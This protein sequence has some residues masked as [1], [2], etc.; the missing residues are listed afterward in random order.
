MQY[1]LIENGQQAGPFTLD[2]LN[3]KKI[4]SESLVWA[5]G[6]T[7]WT[8]AWKVEEL[9]PI[10]DGTYQPANATQ[11]FANQQG[12]Q[13]PPIPPTINAQQFGQNPYTQQAMQPQQPLQP[14]KKNKTILY[15][16]GAAVVLLLF[17]FGCSNPDKSDHKKAIKSELNGAIDELTNGGESNDIF[18]MG[19][20]MFTKMISGP[21]VDEALNSMLDYHSY[22]FYSKTTVEVGDEEK[23]VSYGFLGKVYTINKDDILK[24]I[25]KSGLKV[26][27]SSSESNDENSEDADKEKGEDNTLQG[28]SKSIDEKINDKVDETVDRVTD[29][30]S[31]KVEEKINEKINEAADSSTIEKII[32]KIFSLF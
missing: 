20:K 7:D 12:P 29:H 15:I 14:E 13:V 32:D 30:V 18:S 17:V 10:L 26:E 19:M 6:L 9:R 27:S 5:E 8:P 23:T 11:Q 24:A 21:I 31:K 28:N 16:V 2:Q 22:L 3:E 4:T 25:S 1:F